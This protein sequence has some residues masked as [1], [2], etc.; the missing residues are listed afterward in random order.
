MI[1]FELM[2]DVVGRYRRDINTKNKIKKLAL[3]SEQDCQYFDDLMTKYS[4]YEHSQPIESPVELP[5][6]DDL[7][8]D[9]T[10]LKNWREEYVKRSVSAV[11]G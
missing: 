6:P 8:T 9:M 3:I 1:E 10:A 2:A 5:K 7:L 4:R 11:A